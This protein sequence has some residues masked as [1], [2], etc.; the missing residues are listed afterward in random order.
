MGYII[1]HKIRHATVTSAYGHYG[2]LGCRSLC[3]RFKD[4]AWANQPCVVIGSGTSLLSIKDF[5]FLHRFKTI[6]INRSFSIHDCDIV[7]SMDTNF[8][9]NII[10]KYLD[11]FDGTSSL[12]QW[13]QLRSI[14]VFLRPSRVKAFHSEIYL[15]DSLKEQCISKKISDG[16]CGGNNSGFGGL[17][18]AIAMGA[19]PIYLLGFD[20]YIDE[21]LNKSH[22]HAGYPKQSVSDFKKRLDSYVAGFHLFE[23]KIRDAGVSVFNLNFLSKIKCFPFINIKTI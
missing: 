9:S 14:K 6:A 16:I 7:Y 11:K 8:Y 2:T 17:M 13:N 1:R 20:M 10:C 21:T 22:F 15:I 3:T 4:F 12:N 23:H 18:L 5:S 19:N